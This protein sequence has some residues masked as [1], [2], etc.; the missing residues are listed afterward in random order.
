MASHDDDQNVHSTVISP[1]HNSSIDPTNPFLEDVVPRKMDGD[2]ASPSSDDAHDLG[3]QNTSTDEIK[4]VPKNTLG[5][6]Q[7]IPILA[8]TDPLLE[9]LV[10]ALKKTNS[11]IL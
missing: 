9:V 2:T 11:L 1:K 8:D 4:K 5:T 3:S 10:E 7:H 6:S